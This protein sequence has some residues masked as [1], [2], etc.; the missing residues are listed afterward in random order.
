MRN[1]ANSFISKTTDV[2][3]RIKQL[4]TEFEV[5]VSNLIL[6]E[7]NEHKLP[8]IIKIG[9]RG[10]APSKSSIFLIFFKIS[11]FL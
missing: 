9:Q 7:K 3:T 11:K 10:T 8:K 1:H 5:M 6:R 2:S 4:S